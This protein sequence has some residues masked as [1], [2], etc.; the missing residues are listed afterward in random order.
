MQLSWLALYRTWHGAL[1]PTEGPLTLVLAWVMQK[2]PLA[3]QLPW[4][5][6]PQ[7]PAGAGEVKGLD[8]NHGSAVSLRSQESGRAEVTLLEPEFTSLATP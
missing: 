3:E 4:E 7:S 8:L 1:R 2:S 6:C 5:G